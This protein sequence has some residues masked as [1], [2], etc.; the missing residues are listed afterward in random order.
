MKSQGKLEN[1]F[2]EMVMKIKDIKDW[3]LLKQ[4]RE[5]NVQL[6]AVLIEKM[7]GL[8]SMSTFSNLRVCKLNQNKVKEKK[9]E[10]KKKRNNEE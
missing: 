7:K 2:K 3:V 6:F 5:G 10:E 8:K 9:K 1:I 4:C